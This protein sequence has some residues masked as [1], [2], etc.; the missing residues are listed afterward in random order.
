VLVAAPRYSG[1]HL[2]ELEQRGEA[3][4]V[5]SDGLAAPEEINVDEQR[6]LAL[7]VQPRTE[8]DTLGLESLL[9]E[10]AARDL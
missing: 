7:L 8:L 6:M 5:L 2:H 9:G 3:L 10:K 1:R 4:G